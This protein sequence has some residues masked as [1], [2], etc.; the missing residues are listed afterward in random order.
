MNTL[1]LLV[2]DVN[3][4]LLDL[5]SLVPRFER[6]FGDGRAARDWFAQVILYSEAL[7]LA[8]EYADFG[9]LGGAVVK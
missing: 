5:D 6:I 7:T 8:G 3:E 4:T 2:F 9:E 1:P